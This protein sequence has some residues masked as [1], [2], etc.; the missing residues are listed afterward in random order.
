MR[1][2]PL[3]S[4]CSRDFA[5]P[6]GLLRKKAA[7]PFPWQPSGP[8]PRGESHAIC[9]TGHH[10]ETAEFASLDTRQRELPGRGKPKLLPKFLP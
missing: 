7:G 6:V 3:S 1:I 2:G 10:L 8:W 4:A 5:R 9:G